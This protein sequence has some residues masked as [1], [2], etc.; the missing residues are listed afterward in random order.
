MAEEVA[1]AATAI[2]KA[3]LGAMLINGLVGFVML[4]SSARSRARV[5]LL[6]IGLGH[7]SVLP[8]RYGLGPQHQDRLSVHPD[9]S[10]QCAECWRDGRHDGNCDCG[11]DC[12]LEW[13]YDDRVQNDLV[14][15]P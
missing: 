13:Y 11:D 4:V 2:P 1:N 10:E 3:I 9:L 6:I 7:N 8:G 12:L 14:F 15:R 5:R